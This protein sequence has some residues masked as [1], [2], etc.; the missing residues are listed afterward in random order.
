MSATKDTLI[1]HLTGADKTNKLHAEIFRGKMWKDVS[2][3]W[4]TH[5]IMQ[6]FQQ[7]TKLLLIII[8][9]PFECTEQL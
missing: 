4:K 6:K 3:M 9:K 5:L 1:C 2:I 8:V 7:L